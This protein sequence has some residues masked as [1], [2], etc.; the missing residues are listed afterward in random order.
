[1]QSALSTD[2]RCPWH[3]TRDYR[4]LRYGG[5]GYL[6]VLFERWLRM[7]GAT[8]M[9]QDEMMEW[10]DR[11]WEVLRRKPWGWRWSRVRPDFVGSVWRVE[12]GQKRFCFIG[13]KRQ[14]LSAEQFAYVRNL[15]GIIRK[16]SRLDRRVAL[17]RK[18]A[19]RRWTRMYDQMEAA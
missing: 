17:A 7:H 3:A 12:R 2:E 15:H 8:I 14:W 4:R 16:T 18:E 9:S 5:D 19:Q 11:F 13:G 1:M 10:T 6:G